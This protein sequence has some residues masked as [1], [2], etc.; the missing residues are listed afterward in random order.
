MYQCA[1]SFGGGSLFFKAIFNGEKK[2]TEVKV[3]GLIRY[4]FY[5]IY[6]QKFITHLPAFSKKFVNLWISI[7]LFV[8]MSS[9]KICELKRKKMMLDPV[10]VPFWLV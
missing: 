7:V 4:I 2:F 6:R 5:G 3:I 9:S 1:H 8:L 10:V